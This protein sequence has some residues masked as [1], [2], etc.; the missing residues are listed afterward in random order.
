MA[1]TCTVCIPEVFHETGSDDATP[2]LLMVQFS[3]AS[4]GCH[5]T[6]TVPASL[7]ESVATA[8]RR[9]TSSSLRCQVPFSSATISSPPLN[10]VGGVMVGGMLRTITSP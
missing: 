2:M 6:M 8:F 7:A 3:S 1:R 10:R 9:A 5:S 4:E